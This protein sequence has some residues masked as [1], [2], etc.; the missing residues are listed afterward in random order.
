MMRTL[1]DTTRKTLCGAAIR[2]NRATERELATMRTG[3]WLSTARVQAAQTERLERLLSYA[4]K[5]VPYYTKLLGRFGVVSASGVKIERFREL[6]F[7]D[8]PTIRA[9]FA[10]IT[11]DEAAALRARPNRTGGSTGEPLE[12][13][14]GRDEVRVTGGAVQRLFYEWHGVKPGDR[15][16]K[17]WGSTRDLFSKGGFSVDAFR[18][19]VFGITLLDAF[20]MTPARMAH[21]I[22][23]IN[24]IRPAVLRGYS[25]NLFELAEFAEQQGLPF[26]PPGRVFSSA[27][28]LYP[29]LRAKMEK[30]FRCR[31]YNHYGSRE[32]HAVAM[33]CPAADGLHISAYTQYVEVLD[34]DGQPCPPGVD[35][36]LIIT[37]LLN[38]AMPLVRYRIGDRGSLAEGSCSCGRGLPRLARVSGRRVDCFWTNEGRM[39]PG[40]YFIYLLGVHVDENPFK[41]YQVVQR[42]LDGV[43]Y[44]LVLRPG[45]R[46]SETLR[47][48]IEADT[49]L[50]MGDQCQVSFELLD[51]IPPAASGKYSF[52]ICELDGVSQPTVKMGGNA[53]EAG[54]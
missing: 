28:T 3:Q 46:L 5:H 18:E 51:D 10:T 45:L 34:D 36:N 52:T 2:F 25:S 4:F 48:T 14:Q 27:G 15:E 44:R 31:V 26:D 49:R 12:V 21:Y 13:L 11:S 33:E 35:G 50:V 6:P 53:M 40:E 20:Q 54:T 19:R 8:K 39:I 22:E 9:N 37:N 38:L 43:L 1:T 30:V 47:R 32:V 41:K 23:I 29:H 16:V 42:A 7:L 17:L 24:K